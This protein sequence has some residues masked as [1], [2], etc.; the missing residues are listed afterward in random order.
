MVRRLA[1][2]AAAFLLLPAAAFGDI[3]WKQDTA[4]QRLLRQYV[5]TANAYLLGFGEQ[6]VN[7]L[8]FIRINHSN[9]SLFHIHK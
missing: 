8:L 3:A 4:G 6:P 1:A 2:L 5:E 7:S 9:Q